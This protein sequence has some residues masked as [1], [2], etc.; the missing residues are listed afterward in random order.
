[1]DVF[2]TYT[3]SQIP[4]ALFKVL[5]EEEHVFMIKEES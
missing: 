3:K 1:M 4:M 5:L 2:R